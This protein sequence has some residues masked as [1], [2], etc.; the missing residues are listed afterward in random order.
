M[1][2]DKEGYEE[3]LAES[4]ISKRGKPIDPVVESD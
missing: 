2:N 4:S 1:I 3:Q